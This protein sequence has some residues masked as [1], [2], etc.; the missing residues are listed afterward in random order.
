MN[1]EQKRQLKEHLIKMFE[2]HKSG[3]Y[4]FALGGKNQKD[5]Q[6]D[7][8]VPLIPVLILLIKLNGSADLKSLKEA[9]SEIEKKEVIFISYDEVN[10]KLTKCMNS[11][12][13]RENTTQLKE[14]GDRI[15]NTP[16]SPEEQFLYSH[17]VVR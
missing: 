15:K 9:L 12:T 17:I 5:G 6:K 4:I 3:N 11:I 7:E 14:I 2:S 13:G 16:L 8:Q 1:S 10:A